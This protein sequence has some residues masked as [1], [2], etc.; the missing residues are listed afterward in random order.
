LSIKPNLQNTF[1]NSN[2]RYLDD[3]YCDHY[4]VQGSQL[5]GYCDV[6]WSDNALLLITEPIPIQ[7]NVYYAGVD[8]TD[9]NIGDGV[10]CIHHSNEEPKKITSG[11]IQFY[12]GAIR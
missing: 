7:A 8:I 9:R 6:S 11:Q 10:T 4:K 12:A 1:C 5:I 2:D 3:Y